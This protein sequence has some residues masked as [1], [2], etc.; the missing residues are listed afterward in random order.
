MVQWIRK[1][2]PECFCDPKIRDFLQGQSYRVGS[3]L[4]CDCG[5]VWSFIEDEKGNQWWSAQ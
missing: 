3:Q 1:I 4:T 2:E 5:K